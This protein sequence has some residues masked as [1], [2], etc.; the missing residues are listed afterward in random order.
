MVDLGIYSP[1]GAPS[2]APLADRTFAA[3]RL[4]WPSLALPFASFTQYFDRHAAALRGDLAHAGDMFLACACAYG[5]DGAVDAFERTHTSALARSL[6]SFDPTPAFVEDTLQATREHLFVRTGGAPS[7]IVNYGGRASLQSW[8]SAVAFRWAISARRRKSAQ[9]HDEFS[10][11]NDVRLEMVGPE[12]HYLR[13]RYK[14]VL[15]DAVS[16]AVERLSPKDRLLLKLNVIEGMSIDALGSIYGVG[17]ST[18]ARWLADARRALLDHAK[19]E[20]KARLDVT[21]TELES[22][23]DDLR[24]DLDVNMASLLAGS[25]AR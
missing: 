12:I 1:D 11:E 17:R 4:S 13:A 15:E 10:A 9:R 22:L 19:R 2:G 8:L 3:G 6:A 21:S 23:A 18:A 16:A 24:S 14:N 20:A 25:V 5:V 7:A